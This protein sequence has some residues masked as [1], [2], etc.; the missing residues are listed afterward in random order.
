MIGRFYGSYSSISPRLLVNT[1]ILFILL[2]FAA[3]LFAPLFAQSASNPWWLSLEQG[4]LKFRDG[5]YGDALLFFEDARRNRRSMYEQMER[6]LINFLSI[7]EVRRLGDSLDMLEKFAADRYHTAAFAAIQ[8][9]YYRVPKE[10]LKNSAQLALEAIG[11]LK[12]F[13]EAE[14]WIGEVYR[15]EG[16]LPLALSQ[17]RKAYE[18]RELLEDQ[19]FAVELQ[20][21]IAG[22]LLT[23]QEYNEMI[24]VL[25]SVIA[26]NDSLWK[27]EVSFAAQAMSRT[28]ENEGV[29]RF[30]ELYRYNNTTAE[31]AHRQLGFFYAATGRPAAQQHL[32]QSFLIQNT[33]IIDEIR[34]NRYNFIFT[35]LASLAEEMQKDTFIIIYRKC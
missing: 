28:L 13:P 16:E 29:N 4:K 18:T 8:E 5:D 26:E 35:D 20:Y 32:T 33:I 9:L 15:A 27:D 21:K 30:L 17:F 3:P 34:R 7:N 22:I 6:D 10:S 25:N 31:S 14:F 19:G 12:D 23:R 11:R 1:I 2:T 24:K